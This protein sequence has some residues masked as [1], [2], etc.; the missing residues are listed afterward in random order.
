MG[1]NVYVCDN[2]GFESGNTTNYKFTTKGPIDEVYC[3]ETIGT[4]YT[5]TI[6]LNDFTVPVTLVDN[7]NLS[8]G[9]YDPTLYA[10][11][12][13]IK[14]VNTGNYA[15]KLNDNNADKGLT[16]MSKIFTLDSEKVNFYY[17]IVTDHSS[18]NT[19]KES[20]FIARLYNASSLIYQE[21]IIVENSNTLFSITSSKSLYTGWQCMEF[22]TSTPEFEE[23]DEITLELI[24]IDG[25]NGDYY[26]TVYI[27]DIC[28]GCCPNCPTLNTDVGTNQVDLMQAVTCINAYNT[29]Q[30]DATGAIYHAG[31]EVLLHDGFEALYGS[32]DHFYIEGCTD[33]YV[34]RQAATGSQDKDVKKPSNPNSNVVN[35][36]QEFKV[37]PNPVQNELYITPATDMEIAKLSL[38]AIDGKMIMEYIPEIDSKAYTLNISSVTQGVYILTVETTSGEVISSKVVKN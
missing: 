34:Y 38:Y 31:E 16:S 12:V 29:I 14:R 35:G 30:S 24:V 19:N 1:Q 22:D 3:T 25:G 8:S 23:G 28:D 27:D 5:A 10:D 18:S 7:S 2:G 37:Y 20:R 6:S 26:T 33:E 11:G 9:I 15:I 13:N 32:T 17:S 21:C 36:V 4:A